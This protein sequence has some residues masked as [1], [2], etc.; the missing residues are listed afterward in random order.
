MGHTPTLMDYSR[1]NYVAQ[2][3]DRIDAEDLI[4]KI[5]P[6]DKWATMWGYKPIPGAKSR[7][8]REEDAR[9][10][11]ARAG[12]EAVPALLHREPARHRSGRRDRS[13]RRR[14]RGRWRRRSAS[15]T[16]SASPTCS[17]RRRRAPASRTTISQE[18][19]GRLVG[20]WALETEPRRA[21]RRRLQL[22]AEGGRAAGRHLHARAA[23]A[24]GRR[25]EVPERERVRHARVPDPT[26]HPAAHRAG[27]RPRPHPDGA[28]CACSTTS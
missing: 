27:R 17:S 3:E 28:D 9:R 24:A 5:G 20:Q 19:Y 14:R 6:Y 12:H 26:R 4:P 25:R 7:R 10:V 15:R 16:S 13:R 2:P 1:F 8:R 18:L 22:A 23:R 11:G 21:D